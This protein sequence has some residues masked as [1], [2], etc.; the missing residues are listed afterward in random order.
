MDL[1]SNEIKKKN[2][3]K[4]KWNLQIQQSL[5][6]STDCVCHLAFFHCAYT[7]LVVLI[8]HLQGRYSCCDLTSSGT[9]TFKSRLPDGVCDCHLSDIYPVC[10]GILLETACAICFN[11]CVKYLC[12]VRNPMTNRDI[13]ML[14]L[15]VC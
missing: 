2:F 6:Y 10:W 14:L 4:K 8:L 11:C 12:E 7:V 5:V 15:S 1:Y 9:I 13:C 3:Y